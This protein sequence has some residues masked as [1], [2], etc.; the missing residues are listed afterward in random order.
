[1]K[2]MMEAMMMMITLSKQ[3]LQYSIDDFVVNDDCDDD[4]DD[5]CDDDDDDDDI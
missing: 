3:D 1:M 4:D 2:I 5:E